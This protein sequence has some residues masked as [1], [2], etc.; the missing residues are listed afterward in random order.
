VAIPIVIVSSIVF[1]QLLWK[2]ADVPSASYPYA[3]KMWDLT[4]KTQCLTFSSTMEGGSLFMEALKL[5]YIAWGAGSGIGSFVILSVL[6]L[7]TLLVFGLVRGL[8]QGTPAGVLLEL[9][10]AFIGRFYFRRRFGN[11]WMKYTPVLLA[12][13]SCGMGLVAMVAV[14][15]TILN[16]MM[17]PLVF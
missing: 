2:M 5:K 1:S 17:A 15:F 6:G 16:K 8:G 4:A 9:T 10:G 11:M 12:G 3:Q 7:P 14:S 13:F